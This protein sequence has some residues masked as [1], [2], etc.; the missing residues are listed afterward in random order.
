[1]TAAAYAQ[2]GQPDAAGQA[3]KELL[4]LRPDFAVTAREELL[5]WYAPQLV[6]HLIE[7]L[8]KAGLEL[9]APSGPS[10]SAG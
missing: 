7:G 8:R 3:L 2:L 5:K 1:M 9:P 6:E 4:G 10:S